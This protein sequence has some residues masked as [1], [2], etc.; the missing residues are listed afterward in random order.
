MLGENPSSFTLNEEKAM[1]HSFKIN[2]H[3]F[4]EKYLT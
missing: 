1:F 4:Q 3:Q 2:R